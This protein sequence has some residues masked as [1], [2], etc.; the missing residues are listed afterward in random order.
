MGLGQSVE[1]AKGLLLESLPLLAGFAVVAGVAWLANW[2]MKRRE[3]TF[4]GEHRYRRQAIVLLLLLVGLL[5]VILS[6]PGIEDVTRN[7]LL[8]LFGVLVGA[9][10]T[11]SSTTIAANAMAGLMLRLIRNMRSGDFIEVEG[12]FG[13]VSERGLFHTEIQTEARDLITLPNQY[14]VQHPVKT[15]RS[16]GTFVCATVSLGYDVSH[17]RIREALLKAAA[18]AELS[19]PFVRVLKL[20]DFSVTY[21]VCAFLEDVKHLLTVRSRLR[22]CML[23]RLHGEGIEIVSPAFANQRRF[24]PDHRFLPR[25]GVAVKEPT[26]EEEAKPEEIAFDKAD[27]AQ[28]LEDLNLERETLGKELK[29]MEALLGKT[30]GQDRAQAENAVAEKRARFA[31]IEAELDALKSPEETQ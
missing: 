20:G 15:I 28:R 4:G 19:D 14:L 29:E 10:I 6:V 16:S 3:D 18:D 13:R 11:L 9:V 22:E 1:P 25:H 23:D 12:H 17:A 30:E 2:A 31:E 24:A 7:H 8:T 26:V 5:V 21:R 27:K